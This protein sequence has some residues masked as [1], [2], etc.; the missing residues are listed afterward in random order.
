[1][2]DA[3]ECKR[4]WYKERYDTM[5]VEQKNDK[6]RK[7]CEAR[8]QNKGLPIKPVSSRGDPNL[9]FIIVIP[10]CLYNTKLTCSLFYMGN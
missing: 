5:S 2:V 7:R 4:Q 3:K 8:Q 9:N 1:M 6:N 10:T